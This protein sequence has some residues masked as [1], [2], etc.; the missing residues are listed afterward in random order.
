MQEHSEYFF[1][2]F[3]LDNILQDKEWLLL[4]FD[5]KPELYEYS[6]VIQR[7]D[8]W[9][10]K[11]FRLQSEQEEDETIYRG[12]IIPEEKQLNNY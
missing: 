9:S 5:H 2:N 1:D 11:Y 7:A 8:F 6:G 12:G 10:V 4:P 3:A